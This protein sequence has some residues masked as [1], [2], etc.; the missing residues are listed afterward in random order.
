MAFNYVITDEAKTN[1]QKIYEYIVNNL[2]NKE[3]AD[4]LTRAFEAAI[5]NACI[6]P[7]SYAK[8]KSY[9]KI[10]VED[11][12]IFFKLHEEKK[13]IVIMHALYGAMDYDKCL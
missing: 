3:A 10:I 13:V 2:C 9:R 11:Y 12:L 6:F 1:F 4:R 8:Y 7:K 5:E